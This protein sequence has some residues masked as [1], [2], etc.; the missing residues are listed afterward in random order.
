[1]SQTTALV[2]RRDYKPSHEHGRRPITMIAKIT[3]LTK[4]DLHQ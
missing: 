1:M 3:K 4:E 2:L